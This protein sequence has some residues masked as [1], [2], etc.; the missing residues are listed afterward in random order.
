MAWEGG[1]GVLPLILEHHLKTEGW[2]TNIAA[3]KIG[4]NII[5]N[6]LIKKICC[7]QFQSISYYVKK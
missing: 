4:Y 2:S 1:G 6:I 5:V 3:V 7:K